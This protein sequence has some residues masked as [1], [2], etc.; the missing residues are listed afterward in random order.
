MLDRASALLG[1]PVEATDGAIGRLDDLL[2]DDER[3]TI[4][5][6]VVDAG[7]WLS[8]HRVL[9]APQALGAFDAAQR[10]LPV[11][12]TRRQVE[13]SPPV[14]A[15]AP[16]SVQLQRRIYELH[17][18][19]P[20]WAPDASMPLQPATDLTEALA[21]GGVGV[22]PDELAAGGLEG[23]PRLRSLGEVIGY[24]IE[25]HD[26]E[27]GHAR[28]FLIEDGSWAIRYLVV[29]TGNWLPGRKVLVGTDWITDVSWS[30]QQVTLDLTR[31]QIEDSPAYDPA[32]PLQRAD[33]ERLHER[34]G[35]PGYWS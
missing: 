5:W 23:D 22:A 17:G 8:G 11:R 32:A 10:R 35:R 6:A 13:E 31:K 1:C 9:V 2:F 20:Y 34:I 16:V 15:D 21:P 26:G 28:D 24:R 19:T 7:S 4:R 18:W 3:W 27:L 30:A 29:D 14:A 25:A 12:L 33:E